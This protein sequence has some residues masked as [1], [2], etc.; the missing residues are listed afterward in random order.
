LVILSDDAGQFGVLTHAQCWIHGDR[1]LERL[2][3]F[4]DQYQEEL[5]GVREQVWEYYAEL[6]AYRAAPD[7]AQKEHLSERFDTIFTTTTNFV[8]INEV[9]RGIHQ[10]KAEFLRVL[11]RPEVPLHNNVGE[12]DIREY[13]SIR[14][15]SAGTR[16]D[17]GRRCR[18]TFASLKKT[19][20]KLE[21]PFWDYLLDRLT[22]AG[23]IP[24]LTELIRKKVVERHARKALAAPA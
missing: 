21:V 13:V 19:C 6:K 2:N 3:A 18:D 7:P 12:G 15:V 11:E 16:S 24:R 10:E 8:T 20:R 14:K 9:L 4:N 5:D 1:R 23:K 22:D 17:L